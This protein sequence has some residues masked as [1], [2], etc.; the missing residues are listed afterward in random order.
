MNPKT[1]MTRPLE[2]GGSSGSAGRDSELAGGF[3]SEPDL[4]DAEE[5]FRG[6]PPGCGR[7][8]GEGYLQG[9]QRRQL[10]SR[11]GRLNRAQA[12]V[13]GSA[14]LRDLGIPAPQAAGVDLTWMMRILRPGP[15]LLWR[16]PRP[17]RLCGE[18]RTVHSRRRI[19]LPP[20]RW[21]RSWSGY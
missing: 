20:V 9:G 11:F 10:C 8:P 16:K 18:G 1:S 17:W 12:A 3:R 6:I 14:V 15:L 13:T 7:G 19:H 4:A 2:E 21:S 5:R